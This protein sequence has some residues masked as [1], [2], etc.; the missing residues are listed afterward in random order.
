MRYRLRTLLILMAVGPPVLAWAWLN[1]VPLGFSLAVILTACVLGAVLGRTL[2]WGIEG[3]LKAA[4]WLV[5]SLRHAIRRKQIPNS[6]ESEEFSLRRFASQ[7]K[8]RR[9]K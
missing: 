8:A 1:R 9:K 2:L 3:L 5:A 7:V 4:A 6:E